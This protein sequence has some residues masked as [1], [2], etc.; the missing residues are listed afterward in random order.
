MSS[1]VK[2]KILKLA[3]CII[4]FNIISFNVY[5]GVKPVHTREVIGF[6]K[7]HKV[8][9]IN[10]SDEKYLVQVWLEDLSGNKK[11]LPIIVTPPIFEIENM[12]AGFIRLLP[13]SN[14]LP[15]NKESVFWLNIQEIP[16]KKENESQNLLKMAVRSRIKIF[17]RPNGLGLNGLESASSNLKWSKIIE[18][19]KHYLVATNDS[20][21]YLSMGELNVSESGNKQNLTDRFNMVPPFSTQ[22]YIIPEKFENKNITIVHGI[23]NDYGGVNITHEN[24]I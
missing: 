11:G 24:S 13:V 1:A 21:Y 15:K 17:I 18:N 19:G 6:E 23:I 7:E 5:S 12:R 22:K 20:P 8:D 3:N 16:S 4:L 14:Q 2:N 9:I 10:T